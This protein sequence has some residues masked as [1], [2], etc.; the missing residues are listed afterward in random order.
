MDAVRKLGRCGRVEG[1]GGLDNNK[2][3]RECS[4]DRVRRPVARRARDAKSGIGRAD[5]GEEGRAQARRRAAG[6]PE[7]EGAEVG[8]GEVMF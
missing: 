4:I 7:G 6:G 1:R 3:G 5:L 2:T 8:W